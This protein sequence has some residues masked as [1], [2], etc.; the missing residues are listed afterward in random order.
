[1]STSTELMPGSKYNR[2][3][4]VKFDHK[5]K[6]F[7]RYYLFRCDCGIE[8]VI[9]GAAVTSGNTKSCGCFGKESRTNKRL[10][11]NKGVINH[12]ILQYKRHAKGRGLAWN[13]TYDQVAE[14][15]QEPCF[16]CGTMH[17]NHKVTKNCQ[18]GYDHNGIDRVDSSIG[19]EPRN[20]VPCCKTCNYAKSN[21]TQ[22]DF[23]SWA[24]RVAE[25][26]K[27]MAEQWGGLI[28]RH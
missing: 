17:S 26:S 2:L 16:Y 28:D 10:P 14:I 25:H 6:R 9:H 13:L 24:I 8:K 3:T 22:K 15:I 12:I 21:M 1:M 18:E 27:A 20:V 11:N 7:R 4:V 5:D 23:I 19:Y